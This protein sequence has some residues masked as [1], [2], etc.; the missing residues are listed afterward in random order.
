M[1]PLKENVRGTRNVSMMNEAMQ[2]EDTITQGAGN[3]VI[4]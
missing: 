2:G 4:S 3:N 1:S